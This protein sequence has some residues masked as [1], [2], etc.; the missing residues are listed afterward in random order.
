MTASKQSDVVFTAVRDA[1]LA[2]TLKPSQKLRIGDITAKYQVSPGAARE[3]LSRLVSEGMVNA[4]PQRGFSVA[5]ISRKELADLTEAR[6]LLECECL[7]IAIEKGDIEWEAE[8]VSAHHRLGL[9]GEKTMAPMP[10]LNEAWSQA[11][12][13][14]HTA[15]VASCDNECLLDLREQLYARS[16]RYR[17]WS[18]SLS[19]VPLHNRNVRVE[20]A[21]LM[22][23]VLDR[24]T[25]LSCE[26]AAAHFRKTS[27][28]LVRASD[29]LN[30]E[31]A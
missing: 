27:S 25:K 28:E 1:I 21:E 5:P 26:L 19:D 2:C 10:H 16:E 3:A 31:I 14:F 29:L 18:V 13:L 20:H 15:L 4:L 17:H 30:R 11:H 9:V 8:I 12:S 23:A 6:V 24:N 7:R 22:Q